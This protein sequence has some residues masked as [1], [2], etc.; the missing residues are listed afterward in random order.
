MNRRTGI[1]LAAVSLLGPL[2]GAR[3]IDIAHAGN[4]SVG[5]D[6]IVVQIGVLDGARNGVYFGYSNH[7]FPRVLGFSEPPWR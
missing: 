4:S 1:G 5:G 2:L 6:S 3:T 7:P